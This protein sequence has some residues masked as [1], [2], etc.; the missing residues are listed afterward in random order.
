MQVENQLY[1]GKLTMLCQVTGKTYT[2]DNC[3]DQCMLNVFESNTPQGNP[4][5]IGTFTHIHAF[6]NEYKDNLRNCFP[7]VN[8]RKKRRRSYEEYLT[9]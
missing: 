1:H 2:I 4:V 8:T 3:N 6:L 7:Q 9:N 5:C